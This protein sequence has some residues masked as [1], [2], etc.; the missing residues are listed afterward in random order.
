MARVC[1]DASVVL[2]VLL[3]QARASQIESLWGQWRQQGTELLGC[4]MLY[5]E[6]PSV[7]RE[8][9]HLGH[10]TPEEGQEAFEIFCA[11]DI[12]PSRRDDLHLRVWELGKKV[13]ASRLY[14][15]QYVA[16]ADLEGCQL[17]TADQRLVNLVS[18]HCPWVR[19][20]G[21]VEA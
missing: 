20:V 4:P 10:I 3:R 16:L 21:D 18:G 5:A 14:D 17:W 19:W 9:V 15:I 7:L 11:L 1:I 2:E 13:N 8:K 12:T 6:V